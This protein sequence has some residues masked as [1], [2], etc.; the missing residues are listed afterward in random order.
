[1]AKRR[2]NARCLQGDT[3]ANRCQLC[4]QPSATLTEPSCR[5]LFAKIGTTIRIAMSNRERCLPSRHGRHKQLVCRLSVS[6]S[7]RGVG[8]N[9]LSSQDPDQSIGIE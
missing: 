5:V 3:Y 9:G 8:F 2:W 4:T 7:K 6:D 1:M